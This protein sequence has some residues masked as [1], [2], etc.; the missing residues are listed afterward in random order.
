ME[1]YYKNMIHLSHINKFYLNGKEKYHVL[2]DIQLQVNKGEIFGVVGK[3]GAGKS[4]LIRC[5]NLLE[6]PDSGIVKV[7]GQDL[8]AMSKRELILARR[9]MGM[10]FQHFNLLQSAT[11]Y[12]NIALPLLLSGLSSAK[13]KK[14]VD[15][16]LELV[17]LND[18][19]LN[20][21]SE[22]S[23]GQKQRVAIARALA[24]NPR[25]LLC[26]E[27][28]SALDP[29]TTKNILTLL[30]TINQEMGLTILLITH[31]MDVIKQV[32]DRVAI[33]EKGIIIEEA[34]T[35]DFF[36]APKTLEAAALSQSSSHHELPEILKSQIV[37][38]PDKGAKPLLRI[39][40]RGENAQE[41]L[42]SNAIHQYHLSLNILQANIEQIHKQKLGIMIVEVINENNHLTDAI[43]YLRSKGLI[44]ELLGYISHV[45]A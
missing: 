27:A 13:I 11:V 44:V 22:L 18:K 38:N 3:S 40:F 43:N 20:Y 32:C 33:L 1:V 37:S 31:E 25:I 6:R 30:D 34:S 10:I 23:G 45:D 16:L 28:T 36:M 2:N 15:S 21:P 17:A 12:Q 7:N 9:E 19:K 14:R 8:T 41:P 5:V 4:T 42:I 24:N 39:L 35:T 26:D 29:Q